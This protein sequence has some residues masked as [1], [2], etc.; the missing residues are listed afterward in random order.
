MKLS[1][2]PSP[3][4]DWGGERKAMSLWLPGWEADTW[5]YCF[6][7]LTPSEADDS[8]KGNRSLRKGEE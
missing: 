5:P 6:T 1:P 4:L 2:M 8:L 7:N 3:W